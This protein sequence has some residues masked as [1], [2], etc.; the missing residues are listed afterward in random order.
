MSVKFQEF[1]HFWSTV[2]FREI[3]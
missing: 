3:G 2:V 1:G